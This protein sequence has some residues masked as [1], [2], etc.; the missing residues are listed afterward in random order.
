[1][2]IIEAGRKNTLLTTNNTLDEFR[3]ENEKYL[4]ALLDNNHELQ[5]IILNH[6]QSGVYEDWLDY[7]E[8]NYH[9]LVDLF[10]ANNLAC[11]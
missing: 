4:F 8:K 2:P 7:V 6:F 5:K 3:Y 11:K 1:M 10:K 9:L